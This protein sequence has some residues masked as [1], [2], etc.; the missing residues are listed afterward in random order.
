MYFT[1]RVSACEISE[2]AATKSFSA[3]ACRRGGTD[4]PLA[5]RGSAGGLSGGFDCPKAAAANRVSN[6]PLKGPAD[7]ILAERTSASAMQQTSA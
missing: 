3:M 1:P 2:S 5:A 6:V 4:R 7:A